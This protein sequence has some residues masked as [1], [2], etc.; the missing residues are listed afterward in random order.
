MILFSVLLEELAN[1]YESSMEGDI[2]RTLKV[3]PPMYFLAKK[4]KDTHVKSGASSRKIGMPRLCQLAVVAV[5][6]AKLAVATVPNRRAEQGTK[7]IGTKLPV[8]LN[9]QLGKTS[10]ER[11]SEPRSGT[12]VFEECL[13]IFLTAYAEDLG[14][15]EVEVTSATKYDLATAKSLLRAADMSYVPLTGLKAEAEGATDNHAGA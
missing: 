15:D 13:A 12:G 10:S 2:G 11:K 9:R 7:D 14:L 1:I 5:D 6:H 4:A 3:P 8:S